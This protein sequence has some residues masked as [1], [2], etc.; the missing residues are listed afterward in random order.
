MN[1]RNSGTLTR[2]EAADYLSIS[3]R[4]LDSLVKTS[5]ISRAKIGRRVVFR[6]SDL[7][8]YLASCVDDG[9]AKAGDIDA[10]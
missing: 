5:E 3:T 7:D 6:Q 4:T 9:P 8:D 10:S 1:L 2:S